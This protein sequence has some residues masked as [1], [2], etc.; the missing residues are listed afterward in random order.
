MASSRPQLTVARCSIIA[1]HVMHA[2]LCPVLRKVALA[3]R[4][5]VADALQPLLEAVGIPYL[6]LCAQAEAMPTFSHFNTEVTQMISQAFPCI[7][8]F[9][10]WHRAGDYNRV[11]GRVL[12]MLNGFRWV[13]VPQCWSIAVSAHM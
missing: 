2:L 12:P 6:S 1:L 9:F 7:Q 13:I 5:G 3:C 11:A 10:F 8:R 4:A